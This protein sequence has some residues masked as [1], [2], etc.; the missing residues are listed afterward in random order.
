MPTPDVNG[1]KY[2][3]NGLPVDGLQQP[4]KDLGADKYW[5]T[6]LPM[7]F[8]ASSSSPPPPPPAKL[9]QVIVQIRPTISSFTQ[10]KTLF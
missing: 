7:T 2:W 10:R 1:S 6:G 8:L 4:T 3:F 9:T 5:C